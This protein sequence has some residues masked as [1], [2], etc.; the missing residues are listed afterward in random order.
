MRNDAG[1]IEG[2][3]YARLRDRARS[4]DLGEA[5]LTFRCR[6]E[7]GFVPAV[8][9]PVVSGGICRRSF[10][11]GNGIERFYHRRAAIVPA[12]NVGVLL[13]LMRRIG[14]KPEKA[15]QFHICLIHAPPV[16]NLFG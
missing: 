14:E 7:A 15:L 6:F 8:V 1:Q 4:I 2:V 3:R 10:G 12:A 13:D 11:I 9:R 16:F 5:A